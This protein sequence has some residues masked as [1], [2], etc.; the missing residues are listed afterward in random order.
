MINLQIVTAFSQLLRLSCDDN[1]F[2]YQ[3]HYLESKPGEAP[4]CRSNLCALFTAAKVMSNA[5]ALHLFVQDKEEPAVMLEGLNKYLTALGVDSDTDMLQYLMTATITPLLGCCDLLDSL[6]RKNSNDLERRAC[7]EVIRS[8]ST[9]INLSYHRAQYILVASTSSNPS[10][11][12]LDITRAIMKLG[13]AR[14]SQFVLGSLTRALRSIIISLS[15]IISSNALFSYVKN[16]LESCLLTMKNVILLVNACQNNK[17]SGDMCD[18]VTG[19]TDVFA[20]AYTQFQNFL[21]SLHAMNWNCIQCPSCIQS[22]LFRTDI[23][24]FC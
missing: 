19:I 1:L 18:H 20:E 17:S 16:T 11:K 23:H 12:V 3:K 8:T 7:L 5:T 15:S 10:G 14:F 9:W 13:N 24:I 22:S 6:S 4:S 21:V 2:N